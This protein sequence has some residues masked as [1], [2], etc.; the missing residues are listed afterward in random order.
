[1]ES[2][3]AVARPKP[4]VLLDAP[5]PPRHMEWLQERCEVVLFSDATDDR[6]AQVQAL[7]WYGHDP[8]GPSL[9]S[10]LP[11]LRVCSNFG[12]GYDHFEMPAIVARGI[13]AGHTPGCLSETVAEFAMALLLASSRD[14]VSGANAA[15]RPDF[16]AIDKSRLS[17]QVNGSTLGIVGMG[18]IG[19]AV[20]RRAVAFGQR[21]VY[22]NR[23]RLHE[24][25]EA[26]CGNAHYF[27]A[28]GELLAV[29]DFVLLLCPLTS[30]TVGLMG[31]AEFHQMRRDAHLINMARG[32]VVDHEALVEALRDGLIAAA[33]LDV[34]EPEPLPRDHP[35]VRTEGTNLEGRV[36]LTPHLGSA[37]DATRFEMLRRSVDNLFAGVRGTQLP[38]AVPESRA[39][40]DRRPAAS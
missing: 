30:E 11:R 20:A 2:S 27:D 21:V 28:L 35:L 38:W 15:R 5:F 24:G 7:L 14:I 40:N 16:M 22:H 18:G 17:K 8:V 3:A 29:S 25:V 31:T 23:T 12:A 1:M 26:S 19:Q 32:K 9:L 10:R 36:L 33:A 37:T 39:L 4:L 6:L 34:T 13:P